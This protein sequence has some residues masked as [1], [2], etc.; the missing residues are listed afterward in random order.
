[1]KFNRFLVL[2]ALPVAISGCGGAGG[3]VS[4]GGSNPLAATFRMDFTREVTPNTSLVLFVD[5]AGN[6]GAQL[7]DATEV[8][9]A[10][11]GKIVGQ[12]IAITLLPVGSGASDDVF[13][14]GNILNGDPP[15]ISITLS[16][17]VSASSTATETSGEGVTPFAGSYDGTFGGSEDGT[18]SLTVSEGGDVSGT[19]N[20]PSSGD[21]LTVLGSV[22]ITG[23]ITFKYFKQTGDAHYHGYLHLSPGSESFDGKGT[24]SFGEMSGEWQA[25]QGPLTP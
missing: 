10:G 2:L 8:E 16:G 3:G 7:N 12:H 6:V 11:K 4:S 14:S 5:G 22:D 9:W 17:A 13:L 15:T 1:M 25:E 18:F 21:N 23:K 20:S 24:W 19:L